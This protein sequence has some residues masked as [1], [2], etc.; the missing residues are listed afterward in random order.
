MQLPNVM[1][2]CQPCPSNPPVA[3]S[4]SSQNINHLPCDSMCLPCGLRRDGAICNP[5]VH[6][7][8]H[9]LC[10]FLRYQAV[11]LGHRAEVYEARIQ[12]GPSLRVR[13]AAEMPEGVHPMVMVQVSIDAKHLPKASATIVEKTFWEACFLSQPVLAHWCLAAGHTRG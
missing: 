10:F 8:L 7:W 9:W 12:I 13:S 5:D 1:P 11:Q 2:P 4:R 3:C 6:E